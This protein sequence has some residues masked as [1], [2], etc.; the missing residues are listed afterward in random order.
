MKIKYD[1]VTEAVISFL[2]EQDEYSYDYSLGLPRKMIDLG[3][4]EEHFYS[5]CRFLKSSGL[6]D[7][8]LDQHGNVCGISLGHKLLHRQEF[9]WIDFRTF[10]FHSILV[11]IAV[12]VLTSGAIALCAICWKLFT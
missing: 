2:L 9:F 12:S 5:A 3:I 4:S 8:A 10:M 7:D 11:P 1:K 6:C